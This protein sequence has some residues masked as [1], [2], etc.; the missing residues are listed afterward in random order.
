MFD[1]SKIRWT[2]P[3][4]RHESDAPTY[5]DD[6]FVIVETKRPPP[7][8]PFLSNSFLAPLVGLRRLTRRRR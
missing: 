5:E 4:G 6:G 7:R 1:E 8:D 3:K 2:K